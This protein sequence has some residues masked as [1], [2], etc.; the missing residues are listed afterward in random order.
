[1]RCAA[2]LLAFLTA[3]T[4]TRCSIPLCDHP[5]P[6]DCRRPDD[7]GAGRDATGRLR[8]LSPGDYD[9][10]AVDRSVFDEV[11]APDDRGLLE[12]LVAGATRITLTEGEARSVS[13][14][15]IRR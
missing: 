8:K 2:A 3:A 7:R 5:W 14:R 12:S 6:C 15:V 9:V 4:L 10:T 11:G 13:V 1:M